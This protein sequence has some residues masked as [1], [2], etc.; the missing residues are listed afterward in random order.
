MY[1]GE[2]MFRLQKYTSVIPVLARGDCYTKQ[3]IETIKR[4]IMEQKREMKLQ[5]F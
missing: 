1:D 5:W 4:E 2:V 3:E